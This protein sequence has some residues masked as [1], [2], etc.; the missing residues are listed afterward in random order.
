MITAFPLRSCHLPKLLCAV[1]EPPL[2]SLLQP[3]KHIW[4]SK[5][6]TAAVCHIDQG[7]HTRCNPV[8][9]QHV[10]R[11]RHYVPFYFGMHSVDDAEA[12]MQHHTAKLSTNVAHPSATTTAMKCCKSMH[13]NSRCLLPCS[14]HPEQHLLVYRKSQTHPSTILTR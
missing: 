6:A 3:A 9:S 5:T 12:N 1:I 14:P 4:K 2:V 7:T 13:D 11:L 10:F 8:K